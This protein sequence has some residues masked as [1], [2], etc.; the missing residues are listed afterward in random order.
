MADA[1]GDSQRPPLQSALF[2]SF[3]ALNIHDDNDKKNKRLARTKAR[4]HKIRTKLHEW[5]DKSPLGALPRAM[6]DMR[7]EQSYLATIRGFVHELTPEE[8]EQEK[9][10]V[11]EDRHGSHPDPADGAEE[12]EKKKTRKGGAKGDDE[13][14]VVATVSRT[15][16]PELWLGNLKIEWYPLLWVTFRDQIV[17][18]LVQG[19]VWGIAGLA[20]AQTRAFMLDRRR[21]STPG[22]QAGHGGPSAGKTTTPSVGRSL[23]QALGLGRR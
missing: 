18:P 14:K 12:E 17:S 16:E 23:L 20:L 9:R 4:A 5:E 19:A 8:G 6:P 22:Y 21:I 2:P 13:H 7:F 10:A 15:S 1:A 11:R 3:S